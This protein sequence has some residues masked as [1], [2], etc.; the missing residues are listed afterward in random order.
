MKILFYSVICSICFGF[1]NL[2][3]SM[4]AQRQRL[5]ELSNKKIGMVDAVLSYCENNFSPKAKDKLNTIIDR[6]REDLYNKFG[7]QGCLLADKTELTKTLIKKMLDI[8]FYTARADQ[9]DTNQFQL[10][11]QDFLRHLEE[12]LSDANYN[13]ALSRYQIGFRES[14]EYIFAVIQSTYE[15]YL[16]RN[17]LPNFS[18]L[19]EGPLSHEHSQGK[20]VVCKRDVGTEWVGNEILCRR[21]VK[22]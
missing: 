12:A 10:H 14:I 16:S 15:N 19:N 1:S 21:C 18:L 2:A 6:F 9:N 8:Y 13:A 7:N 22:F 17:N 20:C 5:D 3:F 4:D 11:M